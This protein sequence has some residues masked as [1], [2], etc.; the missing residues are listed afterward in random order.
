MFQPLEVQ[1]MLQSIASS[2]PRLEF[3]ATRPLLSF[4][5]RKLAW[6]K[7][8]DAKNLLSRIELEGQKTNPNWNSTLESSKYPKEIRTQ[9]LNRLKR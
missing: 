4:E 5:V 6:K 2:H 9:L 7:S 3:M 1:P 8:L